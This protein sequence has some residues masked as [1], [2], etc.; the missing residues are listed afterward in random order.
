MRTLTARDNQA[1]ELKYINYPAV[2]P[3]GWEP[4]LP[5][6]HSDEEHDGALESDG[7][8]V[9]ATEDQIPSEFETQLG[10]AQANGNPYL[11]KLFGNTLSDQVRTKFTML[12]QRKRGRPRKADKSSSGARMSNGSMYQQVNGMTLASHAR[13]PSTNALKGVQQRVGGMVSYSNLLQTGAI[14]G[15]VQVSVFIITFE[16]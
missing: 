3:L 10:L 11:D 7:E 1:L 15:R 2:R 6:L 5:V 8:F 16:I 4:P 13:A 14:P 9:H 12:E